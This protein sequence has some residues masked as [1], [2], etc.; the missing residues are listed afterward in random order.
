MANFAQ[1]L[2]WKY[3][4]K[5]ELWMG[6]EAFIEKFIATNKL[7]TVSQKSLDQAAS[8]AG[9]IIIDGR[10]F[11][12]IITDGRFERALLETAAT[13]VA[14]SKEPAR[15]KIPS[16]PGG[17]RG[18]HIHFGGD[19]YLLNDKQWQEFSDRI[20]KNIQEKLANA[21]AINFEQVMEL[22]EAASGIV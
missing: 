6:H 13:S 17:I 11:G 14:K 16:F 3:G 7:E 4:R 22:S 15:L 5:A 1:Q 2:I 8:V 19:I 21:K 10:E 18:P 12:I 20:I 9:G